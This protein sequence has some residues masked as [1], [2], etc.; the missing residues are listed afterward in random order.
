MTWSLLFHSNLIQPPGMMLRPAVF[1]LKVYRAE[2]IP[3]SMFVSLLLQTVKRMCPLEPHYAVVT[4][5]RPLGKTQKASHELI[6]ENDVDRFSA[7]FTKKVLCSIR[8]SRLV[9]R[10]NVLWWDLGKLS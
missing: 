6:C 10:T 1:S 4:K 8:V 5:V 7:S 2:D 3:Q 9:V